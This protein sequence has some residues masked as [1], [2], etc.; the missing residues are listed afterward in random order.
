MKEASF[1]T[2]KTFKPRNP[3]VHQGG[4]KIFVK[5]LPS[6]HKKWDTFVA[7]DF[8]AT[9]YARRRQKFGGDFYKRKPVSLLQ[10]AD[11]TVSPAYFQS[12]SFFFQ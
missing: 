8:K 11:S 3:P 2:I 4:G 12:G 6:E 1:V 7:T 5:Q 10:A 9:I